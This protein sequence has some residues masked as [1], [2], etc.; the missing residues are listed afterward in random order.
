MIHHNR[1]GKWRKYTYY[2]CGQRDRKL[3]MKACQ[4]SRQ[5]NG[6]KADRAILEAILARVMTFDFL[7]ELFEEIRLQ[8]TDTGSLSEEI[9][10][11][12][13][14]LYEL[15]RAIQNLLDLAESFGAGAAKARLKERETERA[16]LESEI[17]SFEIREANADIEISPEALQIALDSWRG[18]LVHLQAAGDIGALRSFLARFVRKIELG[19]YE[20]KIYYTFPLDVIDPKVNVASRGIEIRQN[21]SEFF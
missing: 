11:K 13:H 12:K 2:I 21:Q 19:Y 5:I 9:K 3:G 8:L 15:N 10:R 7:E 14:S 18:N 20:A 1:G 16:I 17:K 6:R 4:E